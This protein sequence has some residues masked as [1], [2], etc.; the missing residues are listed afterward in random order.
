MKILQLTFTYGNNMGAMLQ[1]YALN[2]VL[3]ELGNECHL[4]PMYEDA[5]HLPK[6]NLNIEN[7]IFRILRFYKNR[8][9]TDAWFYR[10]NQFLY[11]HCAFAP[12]VS[13]EELSALESA[14]DLFLV[15]SD[16][17]WNALQYDTAPYFL[18]WVGDKKKRCSYAASLG[19]YSIRLKNDPV[20]KKI[21]EF[22]N[23]SFRERMDYEDALR[24]EM[25]CRLDLDP[26]FLLTREQWM[27]LT[28]KPYGDL[29]DCVVLFGYDKSSFQFAK[30]YAREKGKRF[31]I[32][33]YFGNRMFPGISIYNPSS[34]LELLSVIRHAYCVVTHSY[35]VFILSLN[36]N[37]QVFCSEW[38][39]T[40]RGN[41]MQT[42]VDLFDL[43]NRTAR[44]DN[45]DCVIDWEMFN[46][47]LEGERQRSLAFL[48]SVTGHDR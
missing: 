28:Q 26:T 25:Q 12:Y 9:Y 6:Q 20:A 31:C 34:P 30:A 24:N 32:V 41:R 3:R 22:D 23:I 48:R 21:R 19:D 45:M 14:Y 13:M 10:F 37:K 36:L 43:K 39:N 7:K 16:Q 11:D 1:A 40:K 2:R 27:E 8:N 46:K 42:V 5:F 29:Q 35:H 44:L 4:L 38:K 33:N 17:V 47:K 18:E 15:G